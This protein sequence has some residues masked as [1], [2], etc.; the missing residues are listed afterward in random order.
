M[1]KIVAL[2][3]HVLTAGIADAW[4]ATPD[5][6][7]G[8]QLEISTGGAYGERLLE[9]GERRIA[10]MRDQGVDVQVLS[11]T[12]PGVQN[13]D[14][15][16]AVP[17]AREANDAI[18]DAVA[19]HPDRFEGFATLPTS[20]PDAA[21]VELRRAV[22]ERGL[23]GAM[24]FGRTRTRNLDHPMHSPIWEAAAALR[25]PL[26][27]HPQVPVT[28]VRE[29]YYSGFDRVSDHIFAGP[30]LG[31]HYE[32]GVQLLRLVLSGVFDRYPELQV[33]VGHWGEVVLFFL[34]R[35]TAMLDRA[36]LGLRRPVI[37]YFRHN[38]SYTG[39]GVLD[40]KYLRWCLEVVGVERLLTATDY[41]FVDNGGGA[42]RSFLE[43]ADVSEADRDAIA[44]GN[45][46]RLTS[47]LR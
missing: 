26:Y 8:G 45:W 30:G 40:E 28:A 3:E 15:V 12:T 9:W 31:W 17:L 2:E 35:I 38:V 43:N 24:L 1:R 19:A 21:A 41:P 32:T 18:A 10:S 13:L 42:A 44:H 36:N 37:D 46:D 20:D 16:R 7:Q 4:A 25:A 14:A 34:D 47:H 23:R 5:P 33:V 29:A 39:S 11:V 27:L 6:D 22:T